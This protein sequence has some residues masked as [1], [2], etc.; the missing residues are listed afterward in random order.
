MRRSENPVLKEKV[1]KEAAATMQTA[2]SYGTMTVMGTVN[3]TFLLFGLLL[4]SASWMWANPEYL[5]IALLALPLGLVT[6][7]MTVSKKEWSP[8]TAPIYALCEG[9]V[10]GI[11][12]LAMEEKYPG[13]VGQA[14][15]I[16]FGIFFALLLAYRSGV[17]KATENFKLMVVSAT[18]GIALLYL[19]NFGLM[20]FGMRIPM[21]H[22]SGVI[23]IMF[24]VFVCIIA[25]LNLVLDF[26]FIETGEELGAPK[27]MEWY[28]AF[29]LL[30]TLIWLYLE[31][32]RLLSKSRKRK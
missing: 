21:I 6:C 10:L 17:I 4:I 24:S 13:I 12:S 18:L 2:N 25:A 5:S 19:V 16:T 31:I 22:E 11:I 1:F 29:G 3:K 14:V 8:Y 26:D 15:G 23:G 30:V 7:I 9:V 27:Y 28:G 20:F 32:L